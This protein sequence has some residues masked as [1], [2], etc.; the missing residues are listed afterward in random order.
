MGNK[1]LQELFGEFGDLRK[2]TILYDRSGRSTGQ[3]EI[4]FT[5]ASDA[6]RAKEQ[7]NGVPLDGITK[8]YGFYIMNLFQ[9]EQ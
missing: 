5:R 7:Y 8:F 1:F 2:A 6:E 9:E 3:A 4:E